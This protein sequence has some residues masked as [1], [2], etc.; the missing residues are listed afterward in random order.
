[1]LFLW[2]TCDCKNFKGQCG[3]NISSGYYSIHRLS[4]RGFGIFYFSRNLPFAH[5]TL[6]LLERCVGSTG[7][8]I[9]EHGYGLKHVIT[10]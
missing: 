7:N 3:A 5:P 1:M 6:P 2:A 9:A 10:L 4:N 8:T